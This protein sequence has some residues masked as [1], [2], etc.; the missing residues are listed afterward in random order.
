MVTPLLLLIAVPPTAPHSILVDET[1]AIRP[2]L[3]LMPSALSYGNLLENFV[4][5][6][7]FSIEESGGFSDVDPAK[8]SLYGDSWVWNHWYVDDLD[9]TDPFFSG[10]AAFAVPFR[11]VDSFEV[12]YA[13][14][15]HL[16]LSQGV[17]LTTRRR[18]KR[19]AGAVIHF[20]NA[21]GLVPLGPAV[22]NW[23]SGT[24]AGERQPAPPDE[25][26]RFAGAYQLHLVDS[27]ELPLGHLAYAM[28]I[29]D[30]RRRFLSFAPTGAFESVFEER[31]LIAS[32]AAVL[33]PAGTDYRLTLLGEYRT[34]DRAFAE[35][36]YA[37]EE[38]FSIESGGILLAATVDRLRAGLTF[39]QYALEPNDRDFTRE[40]FDPDGEALRPFR[41]GGHI[42][43][44]KLD[45]R[46][47]GDLVYFTGV[48]RFLVFRPSASAWEN[49]LTA[50]GE[51]YGTWSWRSADTTLLL[52]DD[53]LGIAERLDLGPASLSY[54]LSLVA[55]YA[56]NRSGEN[57]LG[58]LD[59]GME[60]TAELDELET[61][62]PFLS[63]AKTPVA[64]S[65]E[66]ATQL[67]P[68]YLDGELRLA[69]GRL[70]DTTGGARTTLAGR[71]AAT[72]IY[73][74]A[75]G[76][77]VAISEGWSFTAQGILKAYHNTYRLQ[78]DG[79]PDRYGSVVDGIYYFDEG[80]KQYVL[81]NVGRDVP[82][83]F[84]AH[85]GLV[86][87]DPSR[88]V[89][90]LGFSAY[91]V[92]G[93]P[94]FGNGVTAN[95]IGL[96]DPSTANPNSA[97]NQKAN[98]DGDRGFHLKMLLG[99]RFL[100]GLWGFITFRHRD[101]QPFGFIDAHE[102]DGQ[103]AFTHHDTRGS[104]LK[105]GRPLSGPREDAHFNL[106]LKI[107]YQLHA[108]GVRV[109][110][111]LL[112]ANLLDFGNE[113]QEINGPNRPPG[114]PALETQIPRSILLTLELGI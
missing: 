74:A 9:L 101:G 1:F 12:V 89:V 45:L 108:G 110:A 84:G 19:S 39:K 26:R 80:E 32:G 15:P 106:D 76:T 7:I 65:V 22:M 53:R 88:Y 114:R 4:Q 81:E 51:P 103:I 25:R 11:F 104:P 93:Y 23:V 92:I 29:E 46:Y 31:Y 66:L 77:R 91:N 30:G 100:A 62:R 40:I 13:E 49:G 86:G 50:G 42:F 83:Y 56:T 90:S 94:P 28:Q 3:H 64:P 70:I 16:R 99:Y 105:L 97:L 75:L 44:A 111:A 43:A 21:G 96:V 54:D 47:T 87:L 48:N 107:L 60:A 61:V 33:S 58:F 24:H 55:M 2:F 95:D 36:Y 6:V 34:R 38:T 18:P 79:G 52:G 63:L 37:P 41:P 85:F 112:F 71:M 67:D 59:V 69:D 73:S 68:A 5:P 10:A 57:G 14:N 20:P 98:L 82:F 8:F 35:L 78:L 17:R 113:L 109:D 27:I 102:H 72:N